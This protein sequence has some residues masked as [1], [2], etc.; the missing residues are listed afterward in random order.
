MTEQQ[1]IP[2]QASSY[3]GS[4]I[5]KDCCD[6][7]ES[8]TNS[9]FPFLKLP[10]EIQ[11]QI[12][13]WIVG[14]RTLH[15]GYSWPEPDDPPFSGH[16]Y[17]YRCYSQ[18][19]QFELYD[20]YAAPVIFEDKMGSIVP[21]EERKFDFE[22][23][24]LCVARTR[25]FVDLR[26]LGVSK[27][28]AREAHRLFYSS[29]TWN[30]R[31]ADIFGAWLALTPAEKLALVHR[32]HLEIPF[33]HRM[34]KPGGLVDHWKNTLTDQAIAQLPSVQVLHLELYVSRFVLQPDTGS[35]PSLPGSISRQAKG[36]VIA[37]LLQPL[38]KL[39]RLK[40]CTV[41]MVEKEYDFAMR[42]HRR[43]WYFDNKDRERGLWARK[44][45]LRLWAEDIKGL[46]LSR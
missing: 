31:H 14:N 39:K 9:S 2:V 29:N 20:S 25:Y 23:L 28:T 8:S 13:E 10:K 43:N 12:Y 37:E 36:N 11:Y 22:K 7:H 4:F 19:S 3:P 41:V 38:Q 18:Y 17:W 33:D 6:P 15:V 35:P 45:A 46:I 42:L 24:C 5:E 30:F 34:S 40:T 16:V 44:E 26:L 27:E 1:N 21:Q 32:L